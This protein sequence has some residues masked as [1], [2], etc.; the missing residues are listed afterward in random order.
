MK[1]LTVS[2]ASTT[3]AGAFCLVHAFGIG[4]LCWV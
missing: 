4:F 1:K 3:R 2:K